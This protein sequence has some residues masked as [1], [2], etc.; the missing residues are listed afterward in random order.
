MGH[1]RRITRRTGIS[2]VGTVVATLAVT[3]VAIAA[4]P[5]SGTATYTACVQ[6]SAGTMRL[7]DPSQPKA[8]PQSHCLPPETEISWTASGQPGPAG[9]QGPTGPQGPP[10]PAGSD[11]SLPNIEALAGLPCAEGTRYEGTVY[12]GIDSPEA[13]SWIRLTCAKAMRT[14]TVVV[15]CQ[16]SCAVPEVNLEGGVLSSPIGINCSIV[17]TG[18]TCS[19]AFPEGSTVLLAP[20]SDKYG[21]AF[22]FWSGACAGITPTCAVTMNKDQEVVA[23]F[24]AG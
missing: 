7:I 18:Q 11:A 10:G 1:P 23:Y 9:P 5:D 16:N 13:G 3:G 21:T 20:H 17:K 14:L 8:S 15:P 6:K 24:R 2:I 12:V 4:I 22:G 19:A